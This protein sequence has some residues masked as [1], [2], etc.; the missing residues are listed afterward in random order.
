MIH[1]LNNGI[2]QL[3]LAYIPV[4]DRLM[5][6]M[7]DFSTNE[8]RFW[9]TRHLIRRI[10]PLLIQCLTHAQDAEERATTTT[11]DNPADP[12]TRRAILDFQRQ[13][14]L[15][16]ADFKTPYREDAAQHPLGETPLLIT[17]FQIREQAPGMFLMALYQNNNRGIDIVMPHAL[18]HS[19]CRLLIDT[20][21]IKEWRIDLAP[22]PEFSTPLPESKPVLH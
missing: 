8:Y 2:H 21:P 20:V 3:Q 12:Q 6:R 22:L 4:E 9:L 7:R 1:A 13:R 11:Q 18:L 10:W 19:F 17:L 14:F 16:Q 5:L 15:E